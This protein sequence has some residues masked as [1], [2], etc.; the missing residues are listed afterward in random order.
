MN[1]CRTPAGIDE[2]FNE[3]MARAD[4]RT[5]LKRGLPVRARRLLAAI[6]RNQPLDGITSLE[7]GGGAGGF[8]I[9]LIRN[10][11]RE[12]S[13][14]DAS[15]AYVDHARRLAAECGVA[16]R[17][18]VRHGNFAAEPGD[19]HADLIVMDRVVCCFDDW[20]GLLEPASRHATRTLALT[21][22]RNTAW[23][24]LLV[25]T[26]NF[27]MRV[28]RRSFRMHHHSARDMFALLEGAGLAP[29]VEAHRG[30]WEIMVATRTQT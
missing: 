3:R 30:M 29:R 18:V 6:R 20:R 15:A 9:E 24:G 1:C 23:V 25:R 8:S 14:V 26:V 12:A 7:V 22:P 21:Y 19:T 5:F 4:S 2:V 11:V 28:L 13:I 16:Q 17:M 10:G 27:G